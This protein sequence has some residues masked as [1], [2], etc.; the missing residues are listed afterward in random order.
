MAATVERTTLKYVK[1][2]L[3]QDGAPDLDARQPYSN[4]V[5]TPVDASEICLKKSVDEVFASR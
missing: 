5:N 3:M 4:S 1:T 2:N